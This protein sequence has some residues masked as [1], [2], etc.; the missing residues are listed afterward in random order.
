MAIRAWTAQQA[1]N[2]IDGNGFSPRMAL[3]VCEKL[4]GNLV[5]IFEREGE[6]VGTLLWRAYRF[7]DGSELEIY[8][9]GC[10]VKEGPDTMERGSGQMA[11]FESGELT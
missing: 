8:L 2:L 6:P 4:N 3:L 7:V 10:S 5:F 11:L 9:R 1:M